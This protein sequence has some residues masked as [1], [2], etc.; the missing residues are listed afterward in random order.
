MYMSLARPT[1]LMLPAS[2]MVARSPV[3][4]QPSDESVAAVELG[5][6]EVMQH[7][8][9]AAQ[10]DL[11]GKAGRDVVSITV[12]D[13]RLETRSQPTDGRGDGLD[14]VAPGAWPWQCRP[15]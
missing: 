10:Q 8:A 5:V 12:D 7:H 4:S 11:T 15:R 9:A 3:R 13:P 6:V 2:S 14:V 1:I